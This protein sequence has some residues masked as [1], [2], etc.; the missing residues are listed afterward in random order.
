MEPATTDRIIVTPE[1]VALDL[2]VADVGTRLV[3]AILD[4]FFTEVASIVFLLATAGLGS[5]VGFDGGAVVVMWLIGLFTAHFL[6]PM[7]LETFWHGQTLGKRIMGLRVVTNEG[8]PIRFRHAVLRGIIRW[9]EAGPIYVLAMTLTAN[10]QRLGDVFAGT[11]VVRYRSGM[12][13]PKPLTFSVPD[14]ASAF[15]DRIDTSVLT[16]DDLFQLRLLLERSD[17]LRATSAADL[18]NEMANRLANKLKI[19]PLAGMTP[20]DYL[21]AVAVANRRRTR[22][23]AH[24]LPGS[25]LGAT[26]PLPDPQTWSA[27]AD[28]V[29]APSTDFAAPA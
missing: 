3:S 12:G 21:I 4:L 27:P 28:Q 18:T 1:A 14:H 15:V 10:H 13:M 11:V 2:P 19:A 22:R 8:T 24:R 25:L 5:F 6:G 26:T 23:T 7:L 16:R 17:K 29:A 20:R 9:V